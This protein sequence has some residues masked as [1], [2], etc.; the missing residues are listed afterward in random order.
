MNFFKRLFYRAERDLRQAFKDHAEKIYYKA[1]PER[2]GEHE[3]AI[4]PIEPLRIT[5]YDLHCINLVSE[6]IL[7]REMTECLSD[8]QEE[9]FDKYLKRELFSKFEPELIKYMKIKR[10][11]PPTP[12]SV[13]YRAR[14]KFYVDLG[15]EA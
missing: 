14:I 12:Y 11:N 15:E 7:P 10:D 2:I 5:A 13:N 6:V 4:T 8:A 9:E 1:Y 3:L